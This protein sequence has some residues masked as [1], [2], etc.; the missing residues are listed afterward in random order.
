MRTSDACI[1]V[2]TALASAVQ[3]LRG[4]P[5]SP[6][7]W[8]QTWSAPASRCAWTTEAISSALPWGMICVDQPVGSAV[9]DVVVGESELEQILDVVAQAEVELGVV[10]GGRPGAH[11]IGIDHACE[12]GRDELVGAEPFPRGARVL[13]RDEVGVG[14]GGAVTCELEHLRRERREAAPVTW[15]GRRG[16]VEAVEEGAHRVERLA[17]VA[18]RLAVADA[19]AEHEPSGEI[20]DVGDGGRRLRRLVRPDVEDAGRGYQRRG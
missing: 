14:A 6:S 11:R 16:G 2:A 20:A 5:S 19:D 15:R 12:F 7:G 18:R 4:I 17:V 8:R 10:A 3:A 1:Y 9:R 13:D